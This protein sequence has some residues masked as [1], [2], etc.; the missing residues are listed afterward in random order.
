MED[1][2]FHLFRRVGSHCSMNVLNGC[3]RWSSSVRSPVDQSVGDQWPNETMGWELRSLV[4]WVWHRFDGKHTAI[5]PNKWSTGYQWSVSAVE[6]SDEWASGVRLTWLWSRPKHHYWLSREDILSA[7]AD[8]RVG[9]EPTESHRI[10]NRKALNSTDILLSAHYCTLC[11]V[12]Q[13]RHISEHTL[14][15]ES[16]PKTQFRQTSAT[17]VAYK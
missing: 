17:A 13:R 11:T 6:V 15:T 4:A 12:H 9:T 8:H 10:E 1:I 14:Y 2:S 5:A 16:T 7:M 3:L